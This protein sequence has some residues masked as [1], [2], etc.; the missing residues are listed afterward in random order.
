MIDEAPLP[1][2]EASLAVQRYLDLQDEDP[3]NYEHMYE[4]ALEVAELATEEGLL[5][6]AAVDEDD[7]WTLLVALEASRLES[8]AEAHS[9]G[10]YAAPEDLEFLAVASQLADSENQALAAVAESPL[11]SEEQADLQEQ[12]K[13]LNQV[14]VS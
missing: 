10:E 12:V 11:T 1:D 5:P 3:E 6:L 4:A 7:P 9:R 14:L 8:W 13:L 2:T